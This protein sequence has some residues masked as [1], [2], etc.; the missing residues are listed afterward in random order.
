MG[1]LLLLIRNKDFSFIVSDKETTQESENTFLA[2]PDLSEQ[3]G[4][5]TNE[6]KRIT[7]I[8]VMSINIVCSPIIWIKVLLAN[9]RLCEE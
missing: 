9:P 8:G 6:N 7:L 5:N 2:Y 3:N 1:K 4:N